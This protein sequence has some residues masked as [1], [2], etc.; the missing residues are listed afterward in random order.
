MDV[1]QEESMT[2][3]VVVRNAITAG[4]MALIEISTDEP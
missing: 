4:G 1:V 3:K 2:S